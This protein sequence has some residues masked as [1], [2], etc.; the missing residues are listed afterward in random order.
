MKRKVYHSR[1]GVSVTGMAYIDLWNQ[2]WADKTLCSSGSVYKSEEWEVLTAFEL[3]K[4]Q[5]VL[6]AGCGYGR[7]LKA[8][9]D[10]EIRVHGIDF[11]INGLRIVKEAIPE[12]P[13]VQGDIRHLPYKDDCFDLILSWGVM[14]HFENTDEIDAALEK[15]FG[16]LSE[17]GLLVITV[18][19]MSLNRLLN[20][21]VV[22]RRLASRVNWIRKVFGKGEKVFFQY[23]FGV[24]YFRKKLISNKFRIKHEQFFW[25]E[26]GLREDFGFLYPLVKYPVFLFSRIRGLNRLI[27]WV[28]A[29]FML[30]VCEK[31]A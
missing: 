5:R 15:A 11:A 30:F 18:P 1:P 10:R 14:E 28:F 27:R 2:Q 12:I 17:S 9:Y 16:C 7:W 13:V 21:L 8:L 29:P 20:P 4:K 3:L 26:M 22:S 31:T 24:G 19:Y 25:L 23:E 6:E